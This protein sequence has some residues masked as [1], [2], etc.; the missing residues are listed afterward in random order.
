MAAPAALLDALRWP[1]DGAPPAR[2]D[3]PWRTEF[4]EPRIAAT[5]LAEALRALRRKV[6]GT[7]GDGVLRIARDGSTL[8]LP[9]GSRVVCPGR[10]KLQRILRTLAE[11]RHRTPGEVVAATTLVRAG[12]PD[13]RLDADSAQNRLHV[14]LDSIR[15]L[16]L[17]PFLLR[18][19]GGWL[20]AP[21]VP[22]VWEGA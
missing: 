17:R 13:E 12:W 6:D 15:K 22:V 2:A 14:A 8:V 19:S 9:D 1:E 20:L 18:G 5:L 3:W 11:A 7:A 21:S 16:G 10:G 4:F